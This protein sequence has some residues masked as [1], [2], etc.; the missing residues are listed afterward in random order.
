M[1]ETCQ[2]QN[3]STLRDETMLRSREM[4]ALTTEYNSDRTFK[5]FRSPAIRRFFHGRV[6][7]HGSQV[8]MA[9]LLPWTSYLVSAGS[10]AVTN[11]A[12]SQ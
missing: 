11:N 8:E 12:I 9:G 7:Y 4:V 5:S 10:S 3:C 6:S 1:F 2:L